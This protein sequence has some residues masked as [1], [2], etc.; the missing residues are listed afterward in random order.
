MNNVSCTTAPA[1]RQAGSTDCQYI[2]ELKELLVERGNWI[3]RA[4]TILQA[5]R[6]SDLVCVPQGFINEC[7]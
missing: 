6:D 2:E 1:D 5:A 3:A 4:K 7:Q